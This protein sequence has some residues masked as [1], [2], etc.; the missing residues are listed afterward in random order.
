MADVL[1]DPDQAGGLTPG[2]VETMTGQLRQYQEQQQGRFTRFADEG[3]SAVEAGQ[4]VDRENQALEED[5][6]LK[7]GGTGKGQSPIGHSL[8][9]LINGGAEGAWRAVEGL[10]DLTNEIGVALNLNSREDAD[11]YKETVKQN[12]FKRRMSDIEMFGAVNNKAAEFVGEMAPWV[13]TS[14]VGGGLG[15]ARWALTQ[16]LIGGTATT[17]SVT[18]APLDERKGN[19]AIGFG[20]GTT[21]QG[22]FG[23]P[24]A[25][26]RRAAGAMNKRLNT[27]TAAN[28]VELEQSVN[29]MLQEGEFGFSL[30][31]VTGNRFLAGLE[32]RAASSGQKAKQNANIQSLYNHLMKTAKKLGDEG[33]SADEIGLALNDTLST[34]NKQIHRRASKTFSDGLD[35]LHADFGDDIIL[36]YTGGQNYLEK[37]D[38]LLAELDDGLRPGVKPSKSFRAYRQLVADKVEPIRVQKRSVT[39]KDGKRRT[40]YDLFNLRTNQ[41]DATGLG[42][43]A[44]A[45]AKAFTRNRDLGGLQAEEL[46][47]ITRGLND[48]LAGRTAAVKGATHATEDKTMSKAL[49]GVLIDELDS[50]STNKAAVE[51]LEGLRTTYKGEMLVINKMEDMVVNRVFGQAKMPIDP[52]D[53]LDKVMQGGTSSLK[54]TRGFLEE[55]NPALLDELRGTY[56]R[57][58]A[59]RSIDP[60]LPGVDVA[61]S[62]DKMSTQLLGKGGIGEAGMGLFEPATQAD[63]LTT[64]KALRTIKNIYF[65][66]VVPGGIQVDDMTI[67]IISRSPEFMGR[68]LS[69]ALSSGGR[70]SEMLVDPLTR[71]A[72][73][74]IAKGKLSS[75]S[76]VVAML[77]MANFINASDARERNQQDSERRTQEQGKLGTNF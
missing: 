47:R 18:N 23:A 76:G 40:V 36:D 46:V 59:E 66:G 12:R 35:Q 71:K 20:L 30:A 7:R 41:T 43:K 11:R 8:A 6:D 65:R 70:M 73:Q 19:F 56:L 54:A 27:E 49:M 21:L 48:M 58:V 9:R 5:A 15:L 61:I 34:A 51:A 52:D 24:Q 4:I 28:N 1:L 14:T 29:K 16:G 22:A 3:F 75:P 13:A 60:T 63:L 37:I 62:I 45:E 10:G 67:N 55:W 74:R 39:Y 50:N 69:R 33:R 42:S 17:A 26:R 25:I 38:V 64:A 72:L 68:F 53:A 44:K 57:R 32:A 31:Q 2:Q 77:T